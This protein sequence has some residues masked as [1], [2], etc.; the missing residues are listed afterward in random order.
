MKVWNEDTIGARGI[1]KNGQLTGIF[2]LWTFLGE[3][4][5]TAGDEENL[6]RK[7]T[8]VALSITLLVLVMVSGCRSKKEVCM[9][10]ARFKCFGESMQGKPQKFIGSQPVGCKTSVF[11]ACMHG[12]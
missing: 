6:V 7:F 3:S 4:D 1:F 12:L 2:D 10:E 9:E 11:E 8:L 5:R